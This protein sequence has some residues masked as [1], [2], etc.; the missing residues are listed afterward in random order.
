MGAPEARVRLVRAESERLKHYLHSLPPE[1]WRQSSACDRWEVRDVVAHLVLG[2][3]IYA[4]SISRGLRG[5]ASPPV[6]RPPVGS[7][8]AASFSEPMAQTTLARRESLGDQVLTTFDATNDQLNR[9][10]AGLGLQDWDKPCYHGAAAFVAP[11]QTFL[12]LRM[13]ELALHGWDIRS[14]LEPEAHLSAESLPLLIGLIPQLLGWGFWS[15]S[16]LPSLIRYRFH[17]T[18][19]GASHSDLLVAGDT[20]RMEPVGAETAHVTFHC[21]TETFVLLMLGRL[22]LPAALAE[23]RLVAAGEAERVDAFAQWFRGV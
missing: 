6:G 15:G 22:P 18:G 5:D 12:D 23:R 13:F 7:F 2:A 8:N 20:V 17:L 16:R 10:H 11:V 3:E 14:R 21:D 1:A 4:E 9:L 19:P